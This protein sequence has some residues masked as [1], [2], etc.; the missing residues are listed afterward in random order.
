MLQEKYGRDVFLPESG[1]P[2]DL[3]ISMKS[4]CIHFRRELLYNP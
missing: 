4:Y 3:N 2:G 1:V